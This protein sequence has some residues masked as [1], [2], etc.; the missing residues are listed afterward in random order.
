MNILTATTDF[1][2]WVSGHTH[3]VKSQFADKHKAMAE[4][5]VQFLRG[6]FIGGRSCF[7]KSARNCAK[8]PKCCRSG[9][10]TLRASARGAT[11]SDA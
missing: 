8:R 9:I 10:C 6:A 7:P 2:K 1:E 11:G 5:P 3:V 4:S